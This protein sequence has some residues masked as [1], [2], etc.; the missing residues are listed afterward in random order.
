MAQCLWGIA[1]VSPQQQKRPRRRPEE[2]ERIYKCDW[3]GCE[4][5]YGT[6]NHLNGHV[7][8]Q[9]HGPKRTPEEYKEIR[10]ELKARRREER[11]LAAAQAQAHRVVRPQLAPADG[12]APGQY[13]Q[14]YQQW[15]L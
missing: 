5:A 10:T 15:Q 11:Q 13:N 1:L 8:I 7:T 14:V 2:I 6:L 9:S 4:K 12:Q 3:N